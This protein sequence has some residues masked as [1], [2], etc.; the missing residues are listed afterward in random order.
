MYQPLSA[1]FL[2]SRSLTVFSA[3]CKA[4]RRVIALD[5]AEIALYEPQKD[6]FR[7]LVTSEKQNQDALERGRELGREGNSFGWVPDSCLPL[8]RVDLHREKQYT[9]EHRLAAAGMGSYAVL[10]LLIEGKCT[11]VLRIAS[12]RSQHYSDQDA[13]FLLEVAKQVSLVVANLKTYDEIASLKAKLE[14]ENTY[15]Q[16]EIRTTHNF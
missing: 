11:G 1:H 8:F 16:D 2:S 3:V 10:P 14:I 9:D 6:L 7:V 12:E 4:L 5:W 15:L 13:E